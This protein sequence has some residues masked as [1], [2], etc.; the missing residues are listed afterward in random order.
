MDDPEGN[1]FCLSATRR[2]VTGD[3]G[4]RALAVPLVS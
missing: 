4:P 2:S 1:E 3:T